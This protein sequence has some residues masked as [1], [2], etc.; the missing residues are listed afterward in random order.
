MAAASSTPP[1]PRTW[2][3][4][5]RPPPATPAATT[6]VRPGQR[7]RRQ[8]RHLLGHRRRRH[9]AGTRARPGQAGH[10]QRGA[11]ARVPS[12]WAAGGQLRG[13][14]LGRRPV[15]GACR[16]PRA[17]ATSGFWP[18][19]V[20]RPRR[21]GCASPKRPPARQSPSSA[22][23]S[24]LT[25]ETGFRG[26]RGGPDSLR[27]GETARGRG[28]GPRSSCASRCTGFVVLYSSPTRKF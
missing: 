23:S 25:S 22:C 20:S 4:G 18:C 2:P 1:S 16:R 5:R 7:R 27:G 26:S 10:V 17:S 13:G 12:A 14:L 21:C 6:A 3:A 19:A 9:H 24:A 15:A 11:G 28:V 8:P